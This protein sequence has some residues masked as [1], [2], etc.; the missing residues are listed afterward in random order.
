MYVPNPIDLSDIKVPDEICEVIE[1]IAENVHENWALSRINEGWIYGKD[2]DGKLKLHPSLIPYNDLP[3]SEKEYDRI[4]ALETIK[5]LIKNGFDI[6][7]R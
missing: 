7:P 5:L 3:E 4:T 1:M 6:K 2:Y